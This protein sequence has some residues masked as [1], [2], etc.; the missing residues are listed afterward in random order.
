MMMVMMM[1][2]V[3]DAANIADDDY[4]VDADTDG[5]ET[6]GADVDGDDALESYI[7]SAPKQ[8]AKHT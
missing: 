3:T 6:E 4:G 7:T 2:E 8:H 5:D 1:I